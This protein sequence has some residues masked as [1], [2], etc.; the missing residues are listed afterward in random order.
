M[1]RNVRKHTRRNVT[2]NIRPT[3]MSSSPSSPCHH[4]THMK[5]GYEHSASPSTPLTL[6]SSTCLRTE[7]RTSGSSGV[8]HRRPNPA[9]SRH[10]M[11]G[12]LVG[13]TRLD[14]AHKA[15]ACPCQACQSF[16]S[17]TKQ[18]AQSGAVPRMRLS[19]PRPPARL[20]IVALRETNRLSYTS[21]VTYRIVPYL[22][23]DDLRSS[24]LPAAAS[25]QCNLI[26]QRA[27][28]HH[29]RPAA[30]PT[31]A[32]RDREAPEAPERE[33]IHNLAVAL[34]HYQ[35]GF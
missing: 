2:P 19:L 18:M 14:W 30:G 10:E 22:T 15:P 16:H 17:G 33:R 5:A 8:T 32:R 34:V 11:Q 21:Q 31:H 12:M 26:D 23:S 28:Q 3:S 9:L 29:V 35:C 1:G 7:T 6:P 20:S 13:A 25:Q 27:T 24:S 4:V